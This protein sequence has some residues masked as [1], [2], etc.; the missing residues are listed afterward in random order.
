MMVTDFKLT[1]EKQRIAATTMAIAAFIA[2]LPFLMIGIPAILIAPFIAYILGGHFFTRFLFDEYQRKWR[3]V[4]VLLGALM[5]V[6]VTTFL[7]N[8][9]LW[10]LIIFI[11]VYDGGSLPD[12][13]FGLLM[14]PV[15]S[16]FVAAPTGLPCGII[17]AILAQ[18]WWN[19]RRREARA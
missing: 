2:A 12:L 18:L 7:S 4:S 14:L 1:L 15:F 10:L 16:S 19:K 8:V 9:I 5:T 3:W 6:V 13:E 17:G 11:D